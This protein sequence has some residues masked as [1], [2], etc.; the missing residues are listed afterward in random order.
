MR[1]ALNGRAPERAVPGLADH[2]GAPDRIGQRC[3]A[4]EDFELRLV[5]LFREARPTSNETPL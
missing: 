1:K 3:A 4:V 2:A 5:P